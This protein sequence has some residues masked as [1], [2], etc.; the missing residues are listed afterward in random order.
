MRRLS[1]RTNEQSRRAGS[2]AFEMLLI[3]PVFVVLLLGFV[4]LS[5]IVVV[6]ERLSMASGQ[7]AR[8][9]AQGGDTSDVL[10]A[11]KD[12]LGPGTVRENLKPIIYEPS[13]PTTAASG[14]PVKV[15]LEVEAKKTVPDLLRFIGF[16]I[17][18]QMLV[19]QTVMRKE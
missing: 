5:M 13:D 16:S 9:A 7:G 3:L 11:V 10:K 14:T 17:S 6:E 4:E 19:G 15:R 2:A 12:S 8:V 18:N 1:R